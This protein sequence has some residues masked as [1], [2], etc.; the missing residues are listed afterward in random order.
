[1]V[2]MNLL[3]ALPSRVRSSSINLL[4]SNSIERAGEG[5]MREGGVEEEEAEAEA[6]EPD[7]DAAAVAD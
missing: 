6:E 4:K 5:G 3:M 1:M 2:A 7:E